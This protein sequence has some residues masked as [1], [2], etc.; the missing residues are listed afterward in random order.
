MITGVSRMRSDV[1]A[2]RNRA[3]RMLLMVATPPNKER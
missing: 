3:E 2:A 1:L